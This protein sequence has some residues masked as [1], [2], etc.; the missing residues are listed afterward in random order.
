MGPNNVYQVS[1]PQLTSE[2]SGREVFRSYVR[3]LIFPSDKYYLMNE[4]Q[5][6][7]L[8]SPAYEGESYEPDY[9][10]VC[11][12]TNIEFYVDAVFLDGDYA[13]HR[14]NWCEEHQLKKYRQIDADHRCFIA[15]GMGKAYSNPERLYIIP[16]A[17]A[18]FT[19][20]YDTFLEK[21]SFFPGKPIFNG[22]LWRI[23]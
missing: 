7:N 8:N 13:D 20:F 15:L 9:L 1:R 3:Q 19:A 5:R 12:E 18:H 16:V 6:S 17:S 23:T 2:V 14:I 21:Y 11:K 22:A 4:S 10:L